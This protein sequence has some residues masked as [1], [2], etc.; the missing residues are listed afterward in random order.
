VSSGYCPDCDPILKAGTLT[1]PCGAVSYPVR[2]EWVDNWLI[3]A[4]Y[5]GHGEH[6]WGCPNRHARVVLVDLGAECQEVPAVIRPRSCRAIASTTGRQ[7]RHS[8][9]PGSAYCARHDPDRQE[10]R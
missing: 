7:C 8:A 10:A 6:R 1:C 9:R 3:L 5:E 4:E 2:A